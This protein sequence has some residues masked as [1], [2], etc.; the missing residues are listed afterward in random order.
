MNS[1]WSFLLQ[2]WPFLLLSLVL[3]ISVG[4]AEIVSRYKDEPIEAVRGLSGISYL[5]LNG[6][7]SV[8]VCAVLLHYAQNKSTL[9]ALKGEPLI[10]SLLAGMSAMA[11]MRSKLFT[12]KGDGGH[13]YA[14]GPD[15]IFSMFLRT[16]DRK[17]DRHR[18]RRRHAVV[19]EAVAGIRDSVQAIAFLQSSI[20]SFQNL[21]QEERELLNNRVEQIS[22]DSALDERLKLM[23]LGFI[24]LDITGE[25]NYIEFM[26]RLDLYIAESSRRMELVYKE[27]SEIHYPSGAISFLR[28]WLVAFPNLSN[29]ERSE[30]SSMITEIESSSSLLPQ[31]QLIAV[32]NGFLNMLGETNFKNIMAI[33]KHYDQQERDS[34]AKAR[35]KLAPPM[36]GSYAHSD[37][38]SS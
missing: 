13:E 25:D 12:F 20:A 4:A 38:T 19:Y 22:K 30:V 15:V 14:I 36:P 35:E 2:N 34:A 17:I 7:I 26:K 32:C 1:F 37:L 5:I 16:I 29:E 11:L 9:A 24:F 31:F 33:V 3:G 21:S 23:R 28:L 8:F 10:T 6:V 18:V 27:T